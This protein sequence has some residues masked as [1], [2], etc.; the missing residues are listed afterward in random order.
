MDKKHV[1][2]QGHTRRDALK[3]FGVVGGSLA[4]HG[5]LGG[6]PTSAW[7]SSAPG[8]QVSDMPSLTGKRMLVTG[9]TSGMGFEDALAL[10]R[11]GAQVIIAARNG[12]RGAESIERIRAQVPDARVRF[13]QLDLADLASVRSLAQRLHAEGEA[14]DVLINNA[15]I[16]PAP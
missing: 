16:M 11:A 6:V 13:E 5:V 1:V 14:L 7:A 2:G 4:L 12:Q 3:L 8:W 9:G 10:S 15:A